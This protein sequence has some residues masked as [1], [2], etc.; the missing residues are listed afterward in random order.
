V[1][2]RDQHGYAGAAHHLHKVVRRVAGHVILFEEIAA[3][4][5]DVSLHLAGALDDALQCRPKILPQ[6]VC[7]DPV[8]TLGSEG[9]VEMQV[10]EMEQAKGH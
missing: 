4:G 8:E 7:A 2:G 5:D 9:S 3:T 1:A 6:P 10:S